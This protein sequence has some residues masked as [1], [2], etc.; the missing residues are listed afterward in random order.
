MYSIEY[1]DEIED[2]FKKLG[3]R[4]VLLALKKIEKLAQNP[5]M[6]DALGNKAN[7]NLSG[8]KKVYVDNKK[9]RIVYKIVEDR[10]EIFVV[11]VGKRDD[12]EVYKKAMS[13]L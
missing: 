4:I 5:S 2:D 1:H 6:G 11:A 10:I 13:R 12:M 8:L 3:H 7:L 9:V